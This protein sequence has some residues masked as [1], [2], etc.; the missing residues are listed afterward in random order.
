MVFLLNLVFAILAFLFVRY[1]MTE[2]G[3]SR[4]LTLVVAILLAIVVFI[5]NL[6]AQV[7]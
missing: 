6:A 3:A 2:A 4:A 1:A 5:A 7:L